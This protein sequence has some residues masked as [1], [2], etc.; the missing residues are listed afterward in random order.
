MGGHHLIL[1]KTTDFLS[2]REI[3]DNHDERYRQKIARLL[4][5]KKGFAK[6]EIESRIK[7][8]LRTAAGRRGSIWLDFKITIKDRVMMIIKYGPG[9]I[10]TRQT[11]AIAISRL[12]EPYQIPFVVVTNGEDAVIIDGESGS[13]ISSDISSGLDSIP[14]RLSLEKKYS[15][16]YFPP[17]RE[18][19][20]EMA[21]RLVYAY[22]IDGSCP[23][24]ENICRLPDE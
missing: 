10:I 3:E 20:V 17:I 4:V 11:P 21:G 15:S 22:E 23:C 24:D 16:Y 5:G 18:R 19:T 2:G 9:S 13:I 14:D 8:E 6:E 12:I 1:G 7:I